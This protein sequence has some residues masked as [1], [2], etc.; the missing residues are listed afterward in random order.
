MLISKINYVFMRHSRWLFGI[1]TVVIILSFLGFLTP[2]QMGGCANPGDTPVGTA[3]GKPVTYNELR[4]QISF[5]AVNMHMR[6]MYDMN[7]NDMENA[8]YQ[9]CIRRAAEARGITVTD[10]EVAGLIK[11]L[12]GFMVSGKFDY[13]KYEAEQAELKK[14]GIDSELLVKALKNYLYTQKLSTEITASVVITPD[15]VEQFYRQANTEYQAKVAEFKPQAFAKS[16]KVTPDELKKYF[17]ANRDS[18]KIPAMLTAEVAVFSFTSPQALK[19]GENVTDAEVKAWYD[20]NSSAFAKDG[21]PQPF[22]KVREQAKIRCAADKIRTAVTREAQKFATDAYSALDDAKDKAAAFA[23]L[24]AERKIQTVQT[25]TFA[26]GSAAAG[27]IAEPRLV[28]E[29]GAVYSVPVTNAV[30]GRQAA[31][32]GFLIGRQEERKAEFNEA[33]RKIQDG[34]IRMESIRLA[35][36]AAEDEASKLAAMTLDERLKSKVWGKDISFSLMKPCKDISDI[37]AMQTAIALK[38]GEAS[39]AIPSADGAMLVALVKVT[40]PDM[41]EFAGQKM[42]YETMWRQTKLQSAMADFEKYLGSQCVF[43]MKDYR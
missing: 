14:Q 15:E 36:A 42:Q 32:V 8:F 24:A 33:A 26:A 13:K 7:I 43:T 16:V 1:F 38:P 6:L 4:E 27:T 37:M 30:A 18:Y 22:E 5:N 35:R 39:Q 40:P 29:L 10:D 17:E 28:K 9:V 31:Y 2:G 21:K 20:K 41:K 19:Y 11:N 34:F 12:P 3:F 23:K 25:G